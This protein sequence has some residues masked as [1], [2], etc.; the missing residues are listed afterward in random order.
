MVVIS[1]DIEADGISPATA[2]MLQLGAVTDT[3]RSFTV[4]IQSRQGFEGDPGTKK[5]LNDQGIAQTVRMN[6][7]DPQIAIRKFVVWLKNLDTKSLTFIARPAAFDWMWLRYYYDK[8]APKD[9]PT[10]PH[11]AICVSSFRDGVFLTR[12]VTNEQWNETDS[13]LQAR[14]GNLTHDAVQD[15]TDQLEYYQ[16]IQRFAETGAA[17]TVDYDSHPEEPD[18]DIEGLFD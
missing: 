11:K 18:S 7:D 9:A 15:A 5:W 12:G 4:N 10:L 13:Q 1:L 8:Y 3:G 14:R 16:N 17:A 6:A 2:N